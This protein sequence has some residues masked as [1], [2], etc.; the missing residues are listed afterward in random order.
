MWVIGL[1]GGWEGAGRRG[2]GAEGVARTG[3]EGEDRGLLNVME[4]GSEEW[5]VQCNSVTDPRVTGV[6]GVL[7]DLVGMQGWNKT[8]G[9][10]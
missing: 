7:P 2:E 8:M 3:S 1:S 4:P 9:W 5:V 10:Y 6:Q